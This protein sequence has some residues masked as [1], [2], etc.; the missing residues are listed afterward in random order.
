MT[1][2]GLEVLARM[3]DSKIKVR[4]VVDEWMLITYDLPNSDEGNEARQHFLKAAAAIGAVQQTE[5]VYFLPWSPEAQILALNLAKIGG[6]EVIVWGK[7]EPLNHKEEVTARYDAKL[8]PLLNEI[9][10]RLDKM[11]AYKFTNKQ[12][13]VI[14]MIPK[15]E[16]LIQNA[17]AAID[18]R[19]SQTLAVWLQAL[20]ER[21][22]SVMRY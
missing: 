21:F 19:G 3:T 12:K 22:A 16:R 8:E 10:E 11:D 17:K 15:T 20:K 9:V 4:S 2:E 18:R 1:E 7:A 5:S 14:K 6:G 13:R